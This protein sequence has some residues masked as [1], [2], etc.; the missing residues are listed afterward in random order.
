MGIEHCC[1]ERSKEKQVDGEAKLADKSS[2]NV[3]QE[4]KKEQE[5]KEDSKTSQTNDKDYLK[6]PTKAERVETKEDM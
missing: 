4:S 5:S 2:Q 6:I 1:A 3:A